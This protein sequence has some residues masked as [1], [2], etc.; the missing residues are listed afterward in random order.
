MLFMNL[1]K[2]TDEKLKKIYYLLIS[3]ILALTI[4]GNTQDVRRISGYKGIWFTLGQFSDYG[5]KYSGGLG[6]YTAKHVPL[7]I[8][9]PQ[10]NKTLIS[11]T[12]MVKDGMTVVMGGLKKDNKVHI[13]KGIPLLMNI[14]LLGRFFKSEDNEI[15]STEIV[16]FITPH[17]ITGDEPNY[18][19]YRG[20]LK[21]A[22]DYS[23]KSSTTKLGIKQ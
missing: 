5:D 8:Y 7:A 21:A 1:P 15:E 11:T 20:G 12:V 3:F 14:P 17:I 9:A 6:T 2:S 16:I 10:V 13:T 18:D 19:S 22:N 23:A 4:A